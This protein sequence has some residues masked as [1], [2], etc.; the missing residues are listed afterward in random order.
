MKPV[1]SEPLDLYLATESLAVGVILVRESGGK[2]YHVYYVSHALRD[3]KT[4]YL[5][6]KKFAYALIIASRKL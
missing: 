4:R 6:M 5:N 2:Q 3:A 1:L